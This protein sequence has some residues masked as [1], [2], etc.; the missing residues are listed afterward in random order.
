MNISRSERTN[1]PT[2]LKLHLYLNIVDLYLHRLK[3]RATFCWSYLQIQG[4]TTSVLPIPVRTNLH[5]PNFHQFVSLIR[6]CAFRPRSTSLF[7]VVC[8]GSTSLCLSS[9]I[10][11]KQCRDECLHMHVT[12][13]LLHCLRL[14]LSDEI[15]RWPATLI[16]FRIVGY[17]LTPRTSTP[18]PRR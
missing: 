7:T 6:A 15:H 5:T 3:C 8:M 1:S 14:R 10:N 12:W 16:P 18:I 17:I 4:Y 2:F 9:T 11:A 13:P